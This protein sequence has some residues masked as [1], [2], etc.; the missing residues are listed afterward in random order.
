MKKACK[1]TDLRVIQ[2]GF[3]PMTL[4][5]RNRDALSN[6]TDHVFNKDP[7]FLFFNE[8]LSTSGFYERRELFFIDK[9][10]GYPCF[11]KFFFPPIVLKETPINIRCKTNVIL[12]ERM[13]K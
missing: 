13:A 10:P 8:V 3:E 9:S 7:A 6:W 2:I 5:I 4:P 1:K 12:I 11:S